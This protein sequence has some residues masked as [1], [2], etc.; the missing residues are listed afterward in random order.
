MNSVTLSYNPSS[1]PQPISPEQKNAKIL[2]LQPPFKLALH[3]HRTQRCEKDVGWTGWESG[4]LARGSRCS[5]HGR[6]LGV[7]PGVEGSYGV[8]VEDAVFD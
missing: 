2:V 5:G 8:F 3:Q 6:N 4:C 7:G 1:P